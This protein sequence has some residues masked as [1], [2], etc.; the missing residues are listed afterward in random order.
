MWSVEEY[1]YETPLQSLLQKPQ[2]WELI[3]A[4]KHKMEMTDNI[5]RILAQ[6]YFSKPMHAL[7]RAFDLAAYDLIQLD[8]RPPVLDLGCGNGSFGSIFSRVHELN[9]LD[10]GLDLDF[11]GVRLANQRKEYYSVLQT[12]VRDLPIKSGSI[13]SVLSNGV[14]CCVRPGHDL[15]LAEAA[16]ILTPG[17]QYLMTVPTPDFTA[18]LLPKRLFERLGLRR[19]IVWYS[20]GMNK[21]NGHRTLQDFEKWRRELENVGLKVENHLHYFSASEA[22]WWSI[23]AMRPFQLFAIL[24]YLPRF[25]QRVAVSPTEWFVRHVAGHNHTQE[26][27]YGYLLIAAR[28]V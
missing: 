19:L 7:F 3:L 1:R 9:G 27:K 5:P 23:T 21:R 2:A 12:D 6:E 25:I 10:F 17:G 18:N 24:R 14:L 16:R 22:K 15:A 13:G 26:Q 28:K 8:I 11:K 20:N 4:L